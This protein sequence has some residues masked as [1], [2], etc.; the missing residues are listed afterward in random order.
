[1][2]SDQLMTFPNAPRPVFFSS[3]DRPPNPTRRP[4][5]LTA[6]FLDVLRGL[7]APVRAGRQ[8]FAQGLDGEADGR[9]HLGQQHPAHV[10]VLRRVLLDAFGGLVAFLQRDVDGGLHQ[11]VAV[12][13][14][15]AFD[16]EVL[17]RPPVFPALKPALAHLFL[18]LGDGF[19]V[20]RVEE[21]RPVWR[22]KL[23]QCHRAVQLR[24]AGVQLAGADFKL[25]LL[26][27]PIVPV[28]LLLCGLRLSVIADFVA[29][30]VGLGGH[31]TLLGKI[32]FRR[33]E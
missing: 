17:D 4:L 14:D 6:V 21:D 15:D 13:V 28:R 22:V 7:E 33:H 25:L 12:P 18:E 32:L 26:A 9:E 23:L 27:E 8:L 20:G 24:P 19:A 29:Q 2:D 3:S 11:H 1:M 5:A 16:A 10:F 31:V 30:V